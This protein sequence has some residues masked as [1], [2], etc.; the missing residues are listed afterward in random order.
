MKNTKEVIYEFVQCEFLNHENLKGL[1]TGYIAGHLNLQRTN[2]SS[3]LNRLCG[4]G[5]LV[6]ST[7]RPVLYSLPAD[8]NTGDNTCF[9][10][11]IGYDGSLR[12]VVQLAKAAILYPQ[13][14]LTTMIIAEHGCGTDALVR[15]M[16]E[17]AKQTGV[18]KTDAP[19]IKVSCSNYKDDAKA[20]H[21]V[22]FG[23]NSNAFQQASKGILFLDDV[24]LINSADKECITRF[25]EEDTSDAYR[26]VFLIL[27]ASTGMNRIDKTQMSSKIPMCI[28][29]PPLTKRPLEER[30]ELIN[31]FLSIESARA[32]RKIEVGPEVLRMLLLY[33]GPLNVKQIN[34]DIKIASASA[35]V[36][37]YEDVNSNM[38]LYPDDFETYVRKGLLAHKQHMLEV[39][40]LV[41]DNTT[42]VFDSESTVKKYSYFSP[43]SDDYNNIRS[44]ICELEK[45]GVEHKQASDIISE[46]LHGA[47][48]SYK[49]ELSN[50]VIN[51][52]QLRL[53]VNKQI[54]DLVTD[55][56]QSCEGRFQKQYP[57]SVFYGICLHINSL[58]HMKKRGERISEEQVTKIITTY[59]KEFIAC[60]E[61]ANTLSMTMKLNIDIDEI[62]LITMFLI[63]DDSNEETGRP[64][65]LIA[66]HG[67]HTASDVAEVIHTL[68]RTDNIHSFDLSLTSDL[69]DSVKEL[70][71]LVENTDQGKGIIALYDMGSI[72]TMLETIS[73]DTGI[74]IRLVNIPFTLIGLDIARKCA[75]TDDVD[76]VYH[77]VVTELYQFRSD[78]T[79]KPNVFITLCNT[80]EGG[81]V[82]M[83]EYIQ[84]YSHL[85]YAVMPLAISDRQQLIRKVSEIRKSSSVAAFV[86]TF[87]PKIFGI[88]FISIQEVFECPKESIDL[89][90][91]R[92][93]ASQEVD[94]EKQMYQQFEEDLTVI[95]KGELKKILPG[96]IQEIDAAY[97][98]NEDQRIGL[99]MHL[100]AMTARLMQKSSV[101]ENKN[102][103]VILKEH[104]KEFKE[105]AKYLKKLEKRFSI[106]I[107]DSEIANVYEIING[108]KEERI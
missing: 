41:K 45:R 22:L 59:N 86:G 48:A 39:N 5:K 55:F 10:N 68:T 51:T 92:K 13:K 24:D 27:S 80:G 46:S 96:V 57:A 49:R 102:T 19:F 50:Q 71:I 83:S 94:A 37:C 85:G 53:L 6:K 29:L 66:M 26:S 40:A 95:P 75:V 14:S 98:L 42:Y 60:Q 67:D 34:L 16:Y 81:A 82:Q 28:E 36:R 108:L 69:K 31:R 87:D 100:A 21:E 56:I 74:T 18:L 77:S 12:N 106:V 89:V 107:P 64:Q 8:F 30:L 70:E 32:K 73:E 1:E 63:D 43:S 103:A 84:R 62:V 104:G 52:D 61:F 35:Y 4:E 2:A 97:G 58:I 105:I 23:E 88:P 38:V 65:L 54:I 78:T 44:R 79:I 93:P 11:L 15:M 47:I 33:D 76:A 91:E 3:L 17:Y 7:T 25:V 90:L 101:S 9:L 20:L 72:K 99:S